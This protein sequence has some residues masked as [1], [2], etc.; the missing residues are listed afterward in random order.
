MGN[1]GSSGIDGSSGMLELYL[2]PA[3]PN[4]RDIDVG[5]CVCVCVWGGAK[6]SN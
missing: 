4:S 1:S 3:I 5:V 2:H 6:Q